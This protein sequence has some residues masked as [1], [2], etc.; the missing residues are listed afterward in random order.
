MSEADR[1]E[2]KGALA[3]VAAG[4]LWAALCAVLAADGRAPTV[5]LLPV[6]RERYYA[7]QALFVVPV[8][9][10]QWWIASQVSWRLARRLGGTGTWAGTLGP[11][12]W[13]LALPLLV[14]FLLP[15]LVVYLTAGF[16]GLGRV[17]RFTAPTS[18]LGAVVL[19]TRV[20]RRVHGLGGGRAWAAGLAGVLAQAVA[21]GVLLR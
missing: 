14:F 20:M 9:L 12:G 4:L 21:G 11:M 16:E 7:A 5:T 18:L 10:G 15:D 3:V 1:R 2:S 19:A 6:P 17:V 13:A 8:L